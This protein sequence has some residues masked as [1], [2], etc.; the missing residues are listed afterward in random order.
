MPALGIDI[1]GSGIKGAPVDLRRGTLVAERFRVKTP[2]PAKPEPMLDCVAEVFDHFSLPGPVGVTFP[3]VVLADGTV[4]SAPNLHQ[5]WVGLNVARM[6]ADR[7]DR[8]VLVLNDADAAG[9]AEVAHGAA[10]GQKGVTL[11]LTF[12]TGVGSG[13]FVDGTLVPNTE[14]GHLPMRG[15]DAE[16]RVAESVREKKGWSWRKW[17]GRANDYLAMVEQLFSPDLIVIGGGIAKQPDDYLS[18]LETRAP[19]RVAALGNEAGIVG[20]AMMA[21]A[22]FSRR[23]VGRA[24]SA[25]G[26]T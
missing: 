3:G 20:A 5:D 16:K 24:R 7:L 6:A 21:H 17:A 9:V 11:V 22:A 8:D 2:H 4:R 1:G 26:T 10:R 19:L 12:G 15:K 23:P 25:A 13:L 14:L 18:L